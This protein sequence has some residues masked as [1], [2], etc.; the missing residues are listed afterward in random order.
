MGKNDFFATEL[1][2]KSDEMDFGTDAQTQRDAARA[3]SLAY[4]KSR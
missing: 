3:D 1:T 4:E 2:I